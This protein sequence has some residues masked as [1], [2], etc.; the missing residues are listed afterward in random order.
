MFWLRADS[1]ALC[2]SAKH[3]RVLMSCA[4][5]SIGWGAHFGAAASPQQQWQTYFTA[6]FVCETAA[7][8]TCHT[9]WVR[10]CIQARLL[11]IVPPMMQPA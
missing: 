3:R 9:T 10:M 6:D 7:G 11:H 2:S 1:L 4:Y 8:C 5:D